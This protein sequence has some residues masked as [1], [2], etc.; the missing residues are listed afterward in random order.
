MNI[1]EE[2]I[3][4]LQCRW[5]LSGENLA[6]LILNALQ[7]LTLLIDNRRGQGYDGVGSVA[8]YVYGLAAHILRLNSKAV[9]TNCY[10]YRL[11]LVA[12]DTLNIVEVNNMLKHAIEAANF[13]NISQTCN[14]SFAAKIDDSGLE[15]KKGKLGTLIKT[16]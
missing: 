15:T 6:E 11:N 5:V 14:V 8:G 2:F 3:G 10:S 1:R 9:N 12:C 16:K 7:N 4:F 13:I